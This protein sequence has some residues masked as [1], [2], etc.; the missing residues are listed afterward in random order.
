MV[1]IAPFGIFGSVFPASDGMVA[2]AYPI[3]MLAFT[4]ASYS[5]TARA[6]GD[7]RLDPHLGRCGI[8]QPVGFLAGW[9][10]LLDYVLVPGQLYLIAGIARVVFGAV[11]GACATTPTGGE[12]PPRASAET[13]GAG[14]DCGRRPGKRSQ[15]AA[16]ANGSVT[17][18]RFFDFSSSAD[19]A[20]T[21]ASSPVLSALPLPLSPAPSR[22]SYASTTALGIRPRSETS[23]PLA[24]AHSR[25]ATACSRS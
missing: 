17:D 21:S 18:G 10:V 20:D 5:Q 16:W 12:H 2:L 14:R 24:R 6:F 22:L 3:G 25:T 4:A 7:G 15:L 13:K 1:P 23:N 19:A 11:P 9:M 8:A